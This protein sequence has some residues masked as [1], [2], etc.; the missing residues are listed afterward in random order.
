M[1]ILDLSRHQ[2]ENDVL[3]GVEIIPGLT[4]ARAFAQTIGENTVK[5]LKE[6]FGIFPKPQIIQSDNGTCFTAKSVHES[7]TEEGIQWV[8]Q[9]P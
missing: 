9:T 6:R 8:F 7:A 3:V 4:Q 5:A 1:I 2:K